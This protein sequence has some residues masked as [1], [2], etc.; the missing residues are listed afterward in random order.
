SYRDQVNVVC[1]D[2]VDKAIKGIDTF[3]PE[4]VL[5]DVQLYDK[6]GFDILSSVSYKDFSLVFTTAYEHYAID[7]FKFSAIDYLLKPVAKEDFDTAL[8]RAIEREK[9]KNLSERINVL[10]SHLSGVP[11]S[12][13]MSIPFKDG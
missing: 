5:L 13:K 9:Q 8:Q 6:T 1:F 7:A 12:K 11:G 4:I 3:C 2:T 10:L